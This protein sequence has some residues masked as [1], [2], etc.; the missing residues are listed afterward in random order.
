MDKTLIV[1]NAVFRN[2]LHRICATLTHIECLQMKKC[3]QIRFKARSGGFVFFYVV[4]EQRSLN[5]F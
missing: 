1:K 5:Y 2:T 4:L 3:R